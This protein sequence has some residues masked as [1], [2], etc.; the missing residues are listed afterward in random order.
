MPKIYFTDL[1][2][3]NFFAKN[4]EPIALRTDKGNLFENFV[5]RRFYDKYDE[6]DIQFWLTQK[7]HEVDFIINRQKAYEVK[8]SENQ[9]NP[10]KY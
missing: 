3:R 1:G 10:K 4:F 7:K 5:F 9:F 6:M 2:L 8:F